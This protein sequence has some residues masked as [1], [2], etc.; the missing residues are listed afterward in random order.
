MINI[1]KLATSLKNPQSRRYRRVK[2]PTLLQMEAV[3][4]GATA[5]GIVMAYY[6]RIVPLEELRVAAGVSRDGSK[7]SNILKAARQYGFK[8]N[9]YRKS[10]DTVLNGPLPAIIF[11]NFNHFVVLEG[12]GRDKVYLNDPARGPRTVSYDE[13]D[14][15]FTG[16]TLIITPGPSFKAGGKRP[17][18]LLA[19]ARRLRG[20]LPALCYVLLASLC[21]TLLGVVVPAFTRIFVD[22]VL[23]A[24]QGEVVL[25]LLLAMSLGALGMGLFTWLQQRNLLRLEMKLALVGAGTFFWHILRLPIDF[26]NQRRAA[27]I[28]VRV[29][30]NDRIAQLLSGV[31]A[32]NL[33]NVLLIACYVVV[34][35]RYDIGLTVLGVAIALLNIICLRVM[36][37]RQEDGNQRLMNEH[38]KFMSTALNGLQMIE[39]L[40]AMGSESDFFTRWAGYQANVL[41]AEQ[42]TGVTR[43]IM[44]ALPALLSAINIAAMITVGSLAIIEG[45]LSIGG[46][47]AFQALMAAFLLPVSQLVHFGSRLQQT[48]ADMTRIDDVLRYPTDTLA[49][50]ALASTNELSSQKLAGKIELRNV[51][52]GYS[53]LDP[54]LIK[55]FNLTIKPGARVALVGGSGSGKSTIAKLVAGIYTPW[56]GEIC[57]DDQPRDAVPYAQIKNS[58]ALVDQD[59]YLFANTVRENLT[60]WNESIPEASV[61]QAAKDALIHSD[62]TARPGGYEHMVAEGGANFSG[63]QRQRLEIARALAG[64]PTILVMD[65]ATSAL[66]P[67]TEK[68]IDD[69]IRQRGCTCLIVAHRLS[70]IRDCDE[71]IV[72]EKGRVVQ[73][74][75]HD[76]LLRIDGPYVRLIKADET[77]QSTKRVMLDLF[78]TNAP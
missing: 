27:D 69:N 46:L 1:L 60:M 42:E 13:F 32:T 62:I 65:E 52:F 19:L 35:I 16:V 75:T 26:F 58:L 49:T 54:P 29:G 14:G 78:T 31:V 25:P 17:S 66:D 38:G 6:G 68:L 3:E 45:R 30:I 76:K 28:S 24:R 63:G 15:S 20:S 41:N 50:P 59:I 51:T 39:T 73:R 37:R 43:E 47:I 2:T 22:L 61:I 5:L 71:I 9:G 48:Q 4:C 21:L 72:L 53:R 56:S 64:N 33:L 8:A 57:F 70:T 36:A 77:M 44:S 40:K 12:F 23:I 74:G 11:W 7:A 34:M 10:V 55:D 18:L 67:I